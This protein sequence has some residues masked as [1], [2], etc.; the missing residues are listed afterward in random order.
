MHNIIFATVSND[1]SGL[2][3]RLMDEDNNIFVYFLPQEQCGRIPD[4]AD[5]KEELQ[6]FADVLKG[7]K[8]NIVV[9]KNK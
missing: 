3:L 8:V 1:C 4:G 2:D 7:K 5:K 9:E 6:K